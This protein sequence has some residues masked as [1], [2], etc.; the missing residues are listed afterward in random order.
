MLPVCDRCAFPLELDDD[1][2]AFL[3][4]A[5]LAAGLFHR[6]CLEHLLA[7][8]KHHDWGSL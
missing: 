3:G 8:R 6:Q 7:M 5:Q 1:F 2:V 4:D